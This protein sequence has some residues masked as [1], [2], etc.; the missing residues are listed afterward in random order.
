MSFILFLSFQPKD[1]DDC[2]AQF[3]FQK[4]ENVPGYH[5]K[6]TTEKAQNKPSAQ[7]KFVVDTDLVLHISTTIRLTIRN[8]F[9]KTGMGNRSTWQPLYWP[10]NFGNAIE[11]LWASNVN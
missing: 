10:Q 2:S 8:C 5:S 7:G 11:P 6:E 4:P 3:S 9:L 1:P